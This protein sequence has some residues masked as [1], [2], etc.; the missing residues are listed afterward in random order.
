MKERFKLTDKSVMPFGIHKGKQMIDVPADYL[1]WC[2]EQ[3]WIKR[4]WPPIYD[5]I[6]EN[7]AALKYEILEKQKGKVEDS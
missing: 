2:Q 6:Q 4:E 1:I 5:Y 3:D 7:I